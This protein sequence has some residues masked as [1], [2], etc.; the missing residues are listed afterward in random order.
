[1]SLRAAII[2]GGVAGLSCAKVLSSAGCELS[3][4]DKARK[5]GGRC[6]TRRITTG[7]LELRFDHGAQYFTA[8][9]PEFVALVERWAAAG[10][11]ARWTPRLWAIEGQ[12]G[13]RVIDDEVE[14]W[15]CVPS[16]SAIATLLL[17][18][19]EGAAL[20]LHPETRVT[21]LEPIGARW[22]LSDE[23]G[24]SHGL[25]DRVVLDMPPAQA[26]LLLAGHAPALE[27]RV[28]SCRMDPCWA[29]MLR[30]AAPLELEF[31]A[32]FVSGSPLAWIADDGSKP[33][34][35]P[36]PSWVLQGE[37]S[38]SAANLERE[39]DEVGRELVREFER[40]IGRPVEIATLEVHRWRYAKPDPLPELFLLD[41][42][43]IGACGDWLGGPRVEGA[44][45]SGRALGRAL[46]EA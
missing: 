12:G 23:Q 7:E 2:G 40:V 32:A 16:M 29:V 26:A 3:I 4:F 45:L 46:V 9:E 14:R 15:V 37:A 35:G 33:G 43:G 13:A 20:E 34:R 17:A 30:L 24:R 1:M 11:A 8:R 27:P 39:P 42:G 44:F 22:M 21:A 31:D 28:S 41:A 19:L 38:W 25:F 6:S 18:E 36:G 10:Q 5:L